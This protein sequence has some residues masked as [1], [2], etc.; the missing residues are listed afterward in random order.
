MYPIRS[1]CKSFTPT[2]S[3]LTLLKTS[4]KV[5]EDFLPKVDA[6]K[7]NAL[8]D[9]GKKRFLI[10]QA[11]ERT[12]R[13][14]VQRVSPGA[15]AAKS[16]FVTRFRLLLAEGLYDPEAPVRVRHQGRTRKVRVVPS[17]EVLLTE[18]V[19]RFDRR[20]LPVAEVVIGR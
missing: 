8:D 4:S 1:L 14:E 2:L 7:W 3:L 5:Q 19:E 10:D 15:F 16:R 18:F 11:D 6:R 13:L 17:A 12:A 20:F 9:A